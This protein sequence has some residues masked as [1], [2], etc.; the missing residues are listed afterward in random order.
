[1][2]ETKEKL[3]DPVLERAEEYTKTTF[4]LIKLR[5]IA[6]TS[7]VLS[8]VIFHFIL[9]V[10]VSFFVFVASI[11]L[12]LWIGEL[13]GKNYWGFLLVGLFYGIVAGILFMKSSS[14]KTFIYDS[15]V[16]NI[17]D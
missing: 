11:A 7:D 1:M 8:L 14:L 3:L 6:K 13:L 15:V 4:E 5:F 16:D 2:E 12:A 17:M 9:V 10:I